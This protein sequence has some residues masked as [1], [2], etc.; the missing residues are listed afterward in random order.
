MSGIL[1]NDFTQEQKINRLK[2]EI[3]KKNSRLYKKIKREHKNLFNMIWESEEVS[4]QEILD[5]F[6]TD[7]ESLFV[8]SISMQTLLAQVNSEYVPL[9][10]PNEY[11]INE[12]GTVTVGEEK[13]VEEIE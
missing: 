6:G 7:A 2:A 8:Y 9:E 10:T 1:N 11:V 13:I 4:P 5:S 12:D 3:I